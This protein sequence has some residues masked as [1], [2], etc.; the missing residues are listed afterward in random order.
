MYLADATMG[1]SVSDDTF[2][3]FSVLFEMMFTLHKTN[4]GLAL[5]VNL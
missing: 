3:C 1:T 4:I 2:F 5:E